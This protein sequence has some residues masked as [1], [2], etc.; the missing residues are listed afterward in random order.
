MSETLAPPTD[1]SETDP[2]NQDPSTT[3]GLR[4][5]VLAAIACLDYIY[6]MT[7]LNPLNPL[8]THT[9]ICEK[10]YDKSKE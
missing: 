5:L 2:K 4:N 10:G 3:E 8:A 7:E 9:T 6:M 1:L